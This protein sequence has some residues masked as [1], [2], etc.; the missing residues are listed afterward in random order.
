MDSLR[1]LIQRASGIDRFD[2]YYQVGLKHYQK[3]EL[4]RAL[5]Q[6]QT[7]HTIAREYGDSLRIVKSVRI[8]FQM[9]FRLDRADE[10]INMLL[11]AL[12]IAKRGGFKEEQE[13][14]IN[15]LAIT[16]T[17]KAN[18]DRALA[19]H[20]ENLV[21]K[22]QDGDHSEI[23]TSLNNIAIVYFKMRNYPK[24]LEYYRLA[25]EHDEKIEQSDF[26]DQ[27]LI[28]TALCY[29]QLKRFDEARKL[30]NDGL[31]YCAPNCNP[32]TTLHGEFGLGVSYYGQQLY[33]EAF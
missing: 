26:R 33:D 17:S 18:Y 12:A 2:L 23:R 15:L 21:L 22:E 3:N 25:L 8:Q 5:E 10:G 6:F 24:A 13:S 9:L 1:E 32:I 11:E 4:D 16:Y 31:N 20:F 7:A 19:F 28:N 30:I 29:N 27:L 14:I